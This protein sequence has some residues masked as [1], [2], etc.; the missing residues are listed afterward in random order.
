[1]QSRK[2]LTSRSG[3]TLVQINILDNSG[4][5]IRTSYEVADHN[6]DV[7]GR[8]GSLTEAESFIKLLSNLNQPSLVAQ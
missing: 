1:M 2:T 7:I 5:V 4:K 8:F 3:F 6:E